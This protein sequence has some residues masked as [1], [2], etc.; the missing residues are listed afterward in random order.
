[1]NASPINSIYDID[2]ETI[3]GET[4]SLSKYRGKTLLIVNVASKCGFTKQYAGL[5][6][7]YQNHKDEDFVVLGFPCNQFGGQEPGSEEEIAQFCQMNFGV[8]FPMHAKIDVKGD[9]RHPLYTFLT[10][11][12][13]PFSGNVKWNFSKFVVG[14]EGKIVERFGSMTKP[15]SDKIVKAISQSS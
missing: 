6:E 12:D 3:E 5:E 4:I 8:T 14:P 9:N 1:M 10:G 15:T 2:V 11:P 7:L 13:S